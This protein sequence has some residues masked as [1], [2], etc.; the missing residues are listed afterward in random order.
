[1][2][3]LITL[4][5][6][7]LIA[8][9]IVGIISPLIGVFLVVRRLSL[10]ADAL[11]HVTLSGVALGMLLQKKFSVAIDPLYTGMGFSLVG[12]FFVDKI[13]KLYSSYQ[14]LAIPLL[15]SGGVGLGVVLISASGGFSKDIT[16]Y[17][18]GSILS[19]GRDDVVIIAVISAIVVLFI[20]MFYKELFVLSFD[21]EYA[22]VTGVSWRMVNFLFTVITALVVSAS[23]SVVGILLVSA[24]MTI[25]VAT[26]LHFTR[27][28]TQTIIWSVVFSQLAVFSGFVGAYYFNLASGGTIVL[29]SI[30]I[31][32][33]VYVGKRILLS[34][35]RRKAIVE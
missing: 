3:D 26:S 6:D 29:V 31:L 13:R 4:F 24:L 7:P 20:F 30:L 21:E 25:P 23:M 5:K 16:G 35:S 1:M 14:E 15:L 22:V 2:I 19:V 34:I 10:I 12:S 27:S 8:G 11:S 28:F 9:F 33:L 18:F 17:L 32:L